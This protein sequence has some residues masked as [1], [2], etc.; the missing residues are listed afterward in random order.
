[1]GKHTKESKVDPVILPTTPTTYEKKESGGVLG[2]MNEMKTDITTDMK[3]AEIEEKHAN[4][5]YGREMLESKEYRAELV[6]SLEEKKATLA[7]KEMKLVETKKQNEL[8]LEE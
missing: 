5:N 6:K 2:L 4:K 1:M 8:T 3:E 7:D